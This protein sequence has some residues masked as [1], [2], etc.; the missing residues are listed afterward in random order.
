[1]MTGENQPQPIA[2]G[3]LGKTPF[4]HLVLYLNRE[5]LSGTLVVDRSG[6]ETKI[7]F[8]AGKAVAARPLPRGTALQEGLLELCALADSPYAF[9]E[10][11]LLGD[12]PGVVKGTV[13]PLTF[14]ADSLRGH[15]RE[16]VVV[17]V[18]QRYRGVRLVLAANAD[19]RR[20]GLHGQAVRLLERLRAVPTAPEE[21]VTRPE[22]PTDEARRLLYVGL[23]TGLVVP[24][25]GAP[26]NRSGVRTAV[27]SAP[28]PPSERVSSQPA[29]SPSTPSAR[30][31]GSLSSRPSASSLPAADPRVSSAPRPSRSSLP[32]WQQLASLRAA[33]QGSS[34]PPARAP[35]PSMAPPPLE[36]LDDAGKLRRAEQWVERRNYAEAMRIAE[37]LIQHDATNADHEALRAWILYAQL[38]GNKPSRLLIEAID[39]ALRLDPEHPRALYIKGMVLKRLGRHPE[40][41]RAFQRTLEADPKHLEA[42]RE[43]RLAKMRREK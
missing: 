14:V 26:S 28:P 5:G 35:T 9:W 36:A 39:A 25:Q 18:L 21:L 31:P 4:A 38:T 32:A 1:M 42:Q 40:A 13:N 16:A 19:V 10:G 8:R 41:I 15:V 7:L 37:E 34:I 24:A 3:D 11:D 33:A 6:F 43:L 30:A 23:V 27:S 12:S 20:L 17:S 22:L 2:T 29:R